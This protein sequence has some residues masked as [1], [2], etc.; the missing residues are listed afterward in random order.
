MDTKKLCSLF[1]SLAVA[2]SCYAQ[3]TIIIQ[4]GPSTGKD[5]FL[6]QLAPISNFGDHKDFIAYSW[7][8]SGS[9]GIAKSLLQFDLSSIPINSN[10]I[11]AELSLYH[12][13]AT[14]SAGQAGIN[15]SK[16]KKIT[17]PWGEKDVTW[18]TAPSVAEDGAITLASSTSSTQN[19][20]NIDLTSLVREWRSNPFSNYGLMLELIDQ[21]LFNSMKFCSS[22]V[23]D[24]TKR[25][26]LVITYGASIEECVSFQPGSSGKDAFLN[27]LSPDS[28]FGVHPD[29][30]AYSWT[31]AGVPGLGKSLIQFDLSSIPSNSIITNAEFS[32]FY[33]PTTI[34]GGHA[35]NNESKLYKVTSPWSES[36]V[37]WN[38]RPSIDELSAISLPSTTSPNEDYQNINI[39]EYVKNWHKNP[40]TNHGLLFELVDESLLTSMKFSSS[41]GSDQTK[42]PKLAVCFKKVSAAEDADRN[43][44]VNFYPNPVL[45]R[46]ILELNQFSEEGMLSIIDVNGNELIQQ[47]IFGKITHIDVKDLMSGFYFLSLKIGKEAVFKKFVKN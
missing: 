30:I 36:T 43:I 17:S 3:T 34:S 10:I 4:P 33:N 45:D 46:V 22:D 7:T 18:S 6:N 28:N 38:A 31:F 39:T 24:S 15:A 2:F 19:Y 41:D 40:E 9:P 42:K 37:T 11:K 21:S 26:K 13:S 23:D 12:N 8:F 35:G 5:A 27:E 44:E 1:I 32:L 47:K 25:P 16:L 20:S 14:G 29:F